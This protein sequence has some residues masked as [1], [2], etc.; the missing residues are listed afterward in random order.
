[1][2]V[3]ESIWQAY[4]K[5]MAAVWLILVPNVALANGTSCQ[6][7]QECLLGDSCNETVF[8]LTF[9]DIEL[10]TDAETILGTGGQGFVS[11]TDAATGHWITV[12]SSG[13]AYYSVHMPDAELII[14]YTG[15]CEAVN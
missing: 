10:V 3:P 12:T 7:T 8:A 6:F 13:A 1:M 4:G 11:A 14:N 9:N 2:R 15:T 5:R